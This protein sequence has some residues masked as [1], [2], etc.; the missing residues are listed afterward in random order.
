MSSSMSTDDKTCCRREALRRAGAGLGLLAFAGLLEA[1]DGRSP[2][3]AVPP[4]ATS[5][6][7]L[8]MEGG[9]SAVDLF[10]PKPELSKHNGK[11][12][13][14]IVPFGG[15]PGP[16]LASP[17]RFARHGESGA[18]VCD[19]LPRLARCVD[20]LAFVRSM[21]AETNNHAPAMYQMNTGLPR[22]G[23]P[24][25]GGWVTYG[26][27]TENRDLPGFVVLGN[28]M[29]TKGGAPNWGS[30]FLPSRHQG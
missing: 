13:S 3:R 9:P 6:I 29:G 2:A 12:I 11:R 7:W 10:D 21:T 28:R 19:R 20:D 17:F 14:G 16:L 30:G 25:V 15:N 4:R 23:F 22:M 27:G 1:Q 26:L 24:S 18:W 5:V 8:F